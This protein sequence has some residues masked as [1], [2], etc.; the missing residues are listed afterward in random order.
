MAEIVINLAFGSVMVVFAGVV[1]Y[2]IMKYQNE[3]LE[4]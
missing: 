2:N 4:A 1:I 3:E